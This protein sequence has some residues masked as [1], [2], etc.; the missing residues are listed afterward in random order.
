MLTGTSEI[1]G[2]LVYGSKRPGR[3]HRDTSR[4]SRAQG[5]QAAPG[6]A[7]SLPAEPTAGPG[8]VPPSQGSL[9]GASHPPPGAGNE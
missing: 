2:T 8:L 7:S 3:A 5:A 6:G 4:C 1:G 9:R